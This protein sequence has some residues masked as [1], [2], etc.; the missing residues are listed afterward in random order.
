MKT[1]YEEAKRRFKSS[2]VWLAS[3]PAWPLGMSTGPSRYEEFS[4]KSANTLPQNLKLF[5]PLDIG[6]CSS[7]LD[8]I[9]SRQL[10]F[11]YLVFNLIWQKV[12]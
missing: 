9:C 5:L 1:N 4:W 7:D 6:L 3:T 11:I 12:C 2:V 8:S 10:T